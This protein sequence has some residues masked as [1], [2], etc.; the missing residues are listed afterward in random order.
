VILRK[1]VENDAAYAR[2]AMR[3]AEREWRAV[4]ARPLTLI[5]G[6]F[7]L[8]NSAAFYGSDRPSTYSDFSKYLAPWVDDARIAR[9]GI[10]VMVAPESPYWN[11]TE[12]FL[13]TV[14]VA[15]RTEVILT[16]RWLGFESAPRRFVIAVVAPR[17]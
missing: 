7:V 16:R 4:T 14:P 5:G 6:P 10:A 9:D 8:I 2:L 15:R 3:A 17:P 12:N 1:G 13:R 11:M